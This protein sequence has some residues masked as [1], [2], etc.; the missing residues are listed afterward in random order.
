MLR[1]LLIVA[2]VV[3]VIVAGVGAY[4]YSRLAVFEPAEIVSSTPPR[5]V[6][7]RSRRVSKPSSV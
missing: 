7:Q 6:T 5:A 3:L 2:A 1:I 4:L